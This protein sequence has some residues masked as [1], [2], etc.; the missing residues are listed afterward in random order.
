[1]LDVKVEDKKVSF[2]KGSF[3]LLEGTL[4]KAHFVFKVF[5]SEVFVYDD[6]PYERSKSLEING[7]YSVFFDK[8]QALAIYFTKSVK[9]YVDGVEKNYHVSTPAID[10]YVSYAPTPFEAVKTL[11]SVI[12]VPSDTIGTYLDV[13]RIREEERGEYI[14]S[15]NGNGVYLRKR[16]DKL[17]GKVKNVR[18]EI[19]GSFSEASIK[20][21]RAWKVEKNCGQF[22]LIEK[23][24]LSSL[25][26][27][28]Y[29]SCEISSP[30][31][32]TD[33]LLISDN[34]KLME[35]SMKEA[36]SKK[37]PPVF[38]IFFLHN[39]DKN[40]WYIMDYFFVGDSL[41]YVP[42]VYGRKF[43]QIYVPD[44]RYMEISSKEIV[45][46]GINLVESNS[47]LLKEG[48]AIWYMLG[49]DEY[50]VI[51]FKGK[52]DVKLK[53]NGRTITI[54][55]KK[56]RI[57][58]GNDRMYLDVLVRSENFIKELALSASKEGREVSI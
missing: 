14:S 44:G 50:K 56:I 5:P 21:R 25:Q 15:F 53:I 58:E 34:R 10:F 20:V 43:S 45:D 30:I 22:G 3:L 16:D 18:K 31:F 26:K 8:Y 7:S 41:L 57:S 9:M 19:A 12:R 1:V 38:P 54:K 29:A 46:K 23:V 48:K 27:R 49:K 52:K 24:V 55:D 51:A 40:T 13:L 33:K 42:P 4:E 28:L 11:R 37:V 39:N 2:K 47:L 6:A 36:Y 35:S 32:L 17:I